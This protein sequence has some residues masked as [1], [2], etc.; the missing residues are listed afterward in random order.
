VSDRAPDGISEAGGPVY[1]HVRSKPFEHAVG[2]PESLQV[3]GGH[4]ARHVGDPATVFHEIVSD[5]VHI[6]IHVV[7][8]TPA[9]NYYTLVT[10]GMSDRPMNVPK[11]MENFSHLELF[12]SLP[13]TWPMDEKAAPFKDE[14]NYWPIRLL[15]I[16]ARL[17]HEYDT[18]LGLH[19]TMPN[20]DPPAPWADN[21]RLSGA[22]ITI[23][24]LVPAEFASVEVRPGKKVWFLAVTPLHPEEM[25][26]KLKKGGEALDALLEKEGV[27]ELLDPQ[28]KNACRK[29]FLGLF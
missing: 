14:R 25:V 2:D 11:G 7:A 6:D 24:H 22:M 29:K 27:T 1:R 8:P 28:R 9:R 26:F 4:I 10:T 18:W 13:P 5:L 20:G 3:I 15:K 21:T 19:H 12:L 16:L 23:P 17:P